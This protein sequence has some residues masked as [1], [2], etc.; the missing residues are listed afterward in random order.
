MLSHSW[1][2]KVSVGTT[3]V[4]ESNITSVWQIKRMVWN[5]KTW[6]MQEGKL[7]HWPAKDF[8]Q[9]LREERSETLLE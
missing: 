8:Y 9:F 7:K 1:R 6:K 4:Q 3:P 5:R 2:W